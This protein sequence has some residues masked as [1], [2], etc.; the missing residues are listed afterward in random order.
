MKTPLSTDEN[1]SKLEAFGPS[2]FTAETLG[3]TAPRVI[4]CDGSF[5][6]TR[7]G[8]LVL[9]AVW[10]ASAIYLGLQLHH[11]WAP[12]DAGQFGEMADRVLRGQVP[13]RG[14]WEIYSGGL[15]YLD[16]LAMR[17]FGVNLFSIRIPLFLFF[18]GWVPSVYFVAR[19]F[20]SPWLA[21]AITLL[22]VAWSVPN[23]PEAM[24]SWYN[25]FFATWGV[26]ALFRYTE[27]RRQRWL[28]VAGLCGGLSFLVKISGLYYVAAALLF[29]VFREQ[30]LSAAGERRSRVNALAYRIFAS[31]GLLSFL[32][33]VTTLISQRPRVVDYLHFVFPSAVLVAFLLWRTWN[34]STADHAPR[35]RWLFSMAS[36][37]LA[38]ALAPVAVFFLLYMREGAAVGWLEEVFIHSGVHLAWVAADPTPLAVVV[39]LAPIAVLLILAGHRLSSIRRAARY[40]AP[41]ALA[42]LL[43]LAWRVPL[44]RLYLGASLPLLIPVMAVWVAFV[45]W[46]APEGS[47]LGPER[48]FLLVATAVCCALI[49][50]PAA[51]AI[52][53]NYFAPLVILAF[54]SLLALRPR[55]DRLALGSL[56]VF[57]LVFAVW[58]RTPGYFFEN[59]EVPS[60]HVVFR[61]LDL[62]RA[63]GLVIKANEAKEYEELVHL[64]QVHARSPYTYCTPDC[65]EAYFLS[66]KLNATRTIN[67]FADPDFPDLAMDTDGILTTLRDHAVTVVALNGSSTV[68]SGPVPAGLRAALDKRF[69]EAQRVGNFE[70]RWRSRPTAKSRSSSGAGGR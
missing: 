30:S 8:W 56:L 32:A 26:L 40:G 54:L 63:G 33:V 10:A 66:G 7:F 50:F 12:F 22:A 19:R 23:Y 42:G 24:P 15:T 64:I 41:P 34:E 68:M 52:Y 25:L 39:G 43:A 70:V 31:A 29:F 2:G 49:Q 59:R 45:L 20:I 17:L 65:P 67:E 3:E 51:A 46:P 48:T 38:G 53:F 21:G 35:F 11:G 61:K 60:S 5:H 55:F 47:G 18:L 44:A 36:P 57:Y 27:S 6:E 16:A 28:C 9:A 13:D 1:A 62:P 69:P 58:L 14:F 37:F 4:P